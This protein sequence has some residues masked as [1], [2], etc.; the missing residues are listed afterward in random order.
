[1][2]LVVH[3]SSFIFL[4]DCLFCYRSCCRIS[5]CRPCRSLSDLS[6]F[7]CFCPVN[8]PTFATFNT[9]TR[10]ITH[11]SSPVFALRPR[12]TFLCECHCIIWRFCGVI[13]FF[14]QVNTLNGYSKVWNAFTGA[15]SNQCYVDKE[16]RG[17]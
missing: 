16:Q 12:Y 14:T 15:L 9:N 8:F 6:E 2:F 3:S 5:H 13:L 11:F 10:L 4:F 17:F 1:M 7:V